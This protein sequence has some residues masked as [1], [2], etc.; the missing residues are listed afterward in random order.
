MSE[1]I[2]TNGYQKLFEVRLLHHYWLDDGD[3]IFDRMDQEK[4]DAR[5]LNY[6]VRGFFDIAP[7]TATAETIARL[8]GVYKNSALGFLAA[9]P[10]DTG[11]PPDAIFEFILKV[12]DPNFF[13]YT[14]L[15]LRPQ[16]IYELFSTTENKLYRYKENVP[17]FTNKFGTA[18]GHNLFLSRAVPALTNNDSVESFGWDGTELSQL[19]Q[20][21]PNADKIVLTREVSDSVVFFHQGD[22]PQITS[23]LGMAGVPDRGLEL[24]EQIPD[25]LFALIRLSA[26]IGNNHPFNLIDAHQQARNPSPVFQIRFKNRATFWRY[27][28]KQHQPAGTSPSTPLP[29]TYFGNAG[30]RQKPSEGLIEIEKNGTRISRLISEIF[31]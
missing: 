8:K 11:I 30:T 31:V 21:Q 12:K 14:A 1:R 4:Q 20:D 28:D 22:I 27:L 29:L 19:T 15:T 10:A 3:M 7:T 24:S 9:V 13:R 23:P 17:V 6:D 18:K 16:K 25:N 2:A 26:F 5:L